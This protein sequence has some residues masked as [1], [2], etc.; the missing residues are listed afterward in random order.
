MKIITRT[1]VGTATHGTE[2]RD[3]RGSGLLPV[4]AKGDG[5]T[6]FRVMGRV[7]PEGR[8]QQIKA[9]GTADFLESNSWVPYL[10]LEVTS[11]AGTVS[12]FVGEE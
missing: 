1:G 6:T 7:S 10:Q 11:G 12:L 3:R 9:P 4:Q 2:V 8:W 5:A